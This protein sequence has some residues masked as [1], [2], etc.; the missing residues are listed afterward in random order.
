MLDAF[1]DMGA[2]CVGVEPSG[3]FS[4]YLINQGYEVHNTLSTLK[5][6][7]FD[8]ITHFFVFEHIRNPFEFLKESYALLKD[9][10]LIICEIPCANDPLTSI[11]EID[12]FEK[13]YWSIA[14]HYY[15]TPTSLKYVLEKL[16]YKYELIPEQRYDLSNHM[17][18]MMCGKPGGQGK[19]S[20]LFGLELLDM[21]KKRLI[22]TWNC[23]TVF[24]YIWKR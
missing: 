22:E 24:L 14:H 10:G 12:E 18:W 8:L 15:Y 7:K 21:Y 4:E 11:Y 9:N 17:H 23:D 2:N 5:N 6:K 20:E 3:E 16:G 13:F 1:K 19:Y